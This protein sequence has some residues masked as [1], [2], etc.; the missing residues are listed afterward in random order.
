MSD[1]MVS[2]WR[3]ASYTGGQGN[4]VEVGRSAAAIAV[5]DTKDRKSG[6]V[7]QLRAL[8][9]ACVHASISKDSPFRRTGPRSEGP[10]SPSG[11]VRMHAADRPE[12]IGLVYAGTPKI[13]PGTPSHAGTLL[14]WCPPEPLERALLPAIVGTCRRKGSN[15]RHR[16]RFSRESEHE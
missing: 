7:L 12:I 9:V 10:Q 2:G 15:D 13:P 3:V 5:R 11:G 14:Y 1:E 8:R 6:P 16:R 4:C